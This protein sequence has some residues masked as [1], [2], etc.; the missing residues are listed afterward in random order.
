M[1][2]AFDAL[3]D[4]HVISEA[5]AQRM[6]SAVGFRNLAMHAYQSIDWGIVHRLTYEGVDDLRSFAAATARLIP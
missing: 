2:A 3:A 4:V 5:L 1:G 6:R